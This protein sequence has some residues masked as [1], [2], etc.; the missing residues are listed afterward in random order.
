MA[1]TLMCRLRG[2]MNKGVETD[3]SQVQGVPNIEKCAL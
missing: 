1:Y 2:Y 3:F